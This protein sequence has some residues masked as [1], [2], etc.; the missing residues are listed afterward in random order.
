MSSARRRLASAGRS[1]ERFVIVL[2]G[3]RIGVFFVDVREP[4]AEVHITRLS[5]ALDNWALR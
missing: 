4:L 5:N 3:R 2:N 1:V